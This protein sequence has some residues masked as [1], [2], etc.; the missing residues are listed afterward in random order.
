MA[1]EF[2]VVDAW[3]GRF[4]AESTLSA[5]LAETYPDDDEESPISML[6]ADMGQWYYDHDFLEHSFHQTPSSDLES[7]LMPHS[8]SRSFMASAIAAFEALSS[9]P[10]N[11]ILLACGPTIE[12]P[13]SIVREQYRLWYLGRFSCGPDA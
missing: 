13:V 9:P 2:S 4:T 12:S 3:V 7:R 1:K 10:F 11:V 5:Y 8:F 6:A